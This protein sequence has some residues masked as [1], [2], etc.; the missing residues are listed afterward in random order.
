MLERTPDIRN[1][2]KGKILDG[3][4]GEIEFRDV[5][6]TYPAKKDI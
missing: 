5:E 4:K 2:G 1:G 3:L 6:F